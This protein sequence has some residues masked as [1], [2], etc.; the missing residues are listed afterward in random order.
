[1]CQGVPKIIKPSETAVRC[2]RVDIEPIVYQWYHLISN[3]TLRHNRDALPPH[4][5]ESSSRPQPL[6]ALPILPIRSP[7]TP[8]FFSLTT[9]PLP[10]IRMLRRI[11]HIHRPLAADRPLHNDGQPL[12]HRLRHGDENARL[13]Q[14]ALVRRP[15]GAL[16]VALLRA[17]A[18]L[19]GQAGDEE[20]EGGEEDEA[21]EGGEQ[22]GAG[23]GAGGEEVVACWCDG[24]EV[25]GCCGEKCQWI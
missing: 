17:R 18:L 12:P 1:M 10:L 3:R 5:R 23:A 14:P 24:D 7:I 13:V 21:D 9:G 15:A 2:K 16:L 8:S 25:D 20:E 6:S 4:L 19:Q 22:G 11:K